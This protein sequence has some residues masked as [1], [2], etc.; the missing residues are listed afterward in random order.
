MLSLLSQ[1]LCQALPPLAPKGAVYPR[2]LL[3]AARL[4]LGR[5]SSCC[6][7]LAGTAAGD[8]SARQTLRG[9]QGA[10][11]LGILSHIWL[12][13]SR[14]DPANELPRSVAGGWSFPCDHVGLI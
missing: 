1:R 4:Q 10:G 8:T 5:G 14:D 7:P 2:C 3:G 12:C 9:V 6:E 11:L 13:L